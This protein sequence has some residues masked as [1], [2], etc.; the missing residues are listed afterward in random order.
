MKV[1]QRCLGRG[2]PLPCPL[3]D[4]PIL[5]ASTSSPGPQTEN[6]T[7]LRSCTRSRMIPSLGSD[8]FSS[9]VASH[10]ECPA[11]GHAPHPARGAHGS[12][13]EASPGSWLEMQSR[14]PGPSRLPLS[15]PITGDPC[16]Q[17][18]GGCGL[19]PP[20]GRGWQETHQKERKRRPVQPVPGSQS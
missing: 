6:Q 9:E 7:C 3:P 14:G 1:G 2:P 12:A 17:V 19:G 4:T 10:P 11:S 20:Q 13:A 8:P 5:T 15:S 16:A 18:G